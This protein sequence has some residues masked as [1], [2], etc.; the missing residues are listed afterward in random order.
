[1]LDDEM[2]HDIPFE[3]VMINSY[4][5]SGMVNLEATM[6]KKGNNLYVSTFLPCKYGINCEWRAMKWN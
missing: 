2:V 6:V 3:M 5:Q 1:M 4:G